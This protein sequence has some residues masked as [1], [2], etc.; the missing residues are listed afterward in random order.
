MKRV[1]LFEW[2][3]QEWMPTFM[4]NYVTDFLQFLSNKFNIYEPILP[5]LERAMLAQK[6]NQIIDLASGGGGGLLRLNEKLKEKIPNLK[7]LL[8]D[9]FPNITAFEY[10][11]QQADNIDYL[12]I[13]VDARNVPEQLEGLRTQF[14]SLHHFQPQDAQEILQNAVDTSCPIAIFEVQERSIPSFLS[15]L[16]SPLMVLFVTPFIRPFKLGRIIF[17]YIIPI[18][19]FLVIWDGMVSVLRTYSIPEMQN[20][21]N[22]VHR[23]ESFN[24]EIERLKVRNGVILYLLG[25]PR[26]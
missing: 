13:S 11:K 1:H 2:E 6:T 21:V 12:T 20:L 25:L 10:M 16:F 18:I 7:I 24:W 22:K 5:V 4:R 26:T 3:D 17:T 23:N 15:T 9:Y 8:T 14:L 19:P